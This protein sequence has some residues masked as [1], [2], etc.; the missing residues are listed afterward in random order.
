M[1]L[2]LAHEL[3]L[4]ICVA[5]AM[6]SVL[7]GGELPLLWALLLCAPAAT[8]LRLRGLQTPA[9][10]G[11]ALAV[12]TFCFGGWMLW[13][14]GAAA[15]TPAATTALMG[16]TAARLLTRRT[17][18]D[19]LQALV[20]S[21]L[22]I[23]AG[24]VLH[25]RL[26]FGL[27]LGLWGLGVTWAL[28]TRQLVAGAVREAERSPGPAQRAVVLRRLLARR[29]VTTPGFFV[30]MVCVALGILVLA[31]GA[32]VIFP[33]VGLGTLQRLHSDLPRLPS[34]VDLA[35]VPRA[36][37]AGSGSV[38]R[39][40]GLTY[41]DYLRGLYLRA[42][43]FD[44]YAPTGGFTSS[45][46]LLQVRP[47]LL[48]LRPQGEVRTYDIFLEPVTEQS[49]LALGPVQHA[50]VLTGGDANPS[51]RTHL[52][53]LGPAGE[54]LPMAPLTGPIRYQVEGMLATPPRP[55]TVGAARLRK[56]YEAGSGRTAA[57]RPS[58]D[59]GSEDR[60]S[61]GGSPVVRASADE[62]PADETPV[63]EIPVD[64]TS[65][66]G[67][68]M[69][70][71]SE[72]QGRAFSEH[73]LALPTRL[74]PRITALA[75]RLTAGLPNRAAQVQAVRQHLLTHM[76]YAQNPLNGRRADPLSGFLFED[77]RGHC[78]YFATAFAV[79]LR[80]AH[81]PSR[82]VGGFAFGTWDPDAQ[83][84]LFAGGDA[85]AWV[86][87]YVPGSGW[88]VDDATPPGPPLQ[89]SGWAAVSERLRR[90]W[91]D[92]VVQFGL[93]EQ[94]ELVSQMVGTLR[95]PT[96]LHSAGF[97]WQ[98]RH[99]V[100]VGSLVALGALTLGWRQLRRRGH[101]GGRTLRPVDGLLQALLNCLHRL[102]GSPVAAAATLRQAVEAAL[103]QPQKT[104]TPPQQAVLRAALQHYELQ[105]FGA[106]ERD[107]KP[108]DAAQQAAAVRQLTDELL[109]L[110]AA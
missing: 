31:A 61:A 37:F 9:W 110:P 48:A 106:L 59:G 85:H 33:R 74:D 12:A 44:T 10:A 8:V 7:L 103:A 109:R 27:M 65:V 75:Q 87:W 80:A 51:L 18:T 96:S 26:T 60:P 77:P 95:G 15:A 20:L 42:A 50:A 105:R 62:T 4:L 69:N 23:F 39:L 94:L 68:N 28:L 84:V 58:A 70:S 1:S 89:L 54:L 79:L 40:R 76:A 97:V 5:S 66:D 90:L 91:D 35:G 34:S 83:L 19:D 101:L 29:D 100:A 38:A 2:Q 55:G 47:H 22:L 52:V 24:T 81:I 16:I 21:L 67:P 98:R 43:V 53:G 73:F 46:T 45:G 25:Q 86:E 72:E 104:L 32:F 49:L 41:A 102:S 11:T 92:K 78:E 57:G 3:G 6:L 13:H 93:Q 108:V 63:N 17:P 71:P 99:T 36:S 14:Q 82:V 64:K 56:L 88:Q 107:I 30:V